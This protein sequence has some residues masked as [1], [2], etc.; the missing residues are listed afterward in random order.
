M[1][2]GGYRFVLVEI[3]FKSF[4]ANNIADLADLSRA[5]AFFS[6]RSMLATLSRSLV[7]LA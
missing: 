6:S 2:V 7:R 5:F 3:F 4:S 1:Q